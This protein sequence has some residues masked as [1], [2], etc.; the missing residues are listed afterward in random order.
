MKAS[1][2]ADRSGKSSDGLASGAGPRAGGRLV[3]EMLMMFRITSPQRTKIVLLGVAIVLVIAATAF[4]QIRLNA[5]N[6]PFYNALQRR[7]LHGF[8]VQLVIFCIIAGALLVLNVVQTWINQATKVKLREGLVGDLFDQWL[9]NRRAFRLTYAGEI[10]ANPDQRI[11]EDARHLTELSTDLGIGLLQSSLLLGSFIGVLWILS[12]NVTFHVNGRSFAIPGYMVWCA[13]V[14]AST[15]SW[16]SWRVG[17]PLIQLNSEH[18]AREADLRFALV[19]LN[20]HS[21]SV[22]LLAANR[23]R[24]SASIPSSRTFS[25]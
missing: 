13:L 18:Y 4:G 17:R 14:Y 20:E 3:S 8:L 25:A 9:R 24:S 21:D 23:M 6:Q 7:D 12:R 5:W 19:R 1:S 22:A 15:A 11:H 2:M 10:G 16:L